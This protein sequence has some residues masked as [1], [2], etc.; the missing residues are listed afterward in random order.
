MKKNETEKGEEIKIRR[1]RG[2]N[3]QRQIKEIISY[4]N[5]LISPSYNN[6]LEKYSNL[7]N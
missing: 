6:S 2:D 1:K 4:R 7:R 3:C 5:K